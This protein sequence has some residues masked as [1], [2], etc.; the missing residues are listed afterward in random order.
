MPKAS[1]P[2]ADYDP[3]KDS[4]LAHRC[5]RKF[6]LT[7]L[8]ADYDDA[9]QVALIGLMKARETWKPD[10]RPWPIWATIIVF[11]HLQRWN[12]VRLRNGL[13]D[14]RD[15]PD[16][17]DPQTPPIHLTLNPSNVAGDD[18]D[19]ALSLDRDERSERIRALVAGLPER[20][21]FI[22]EGI[23]AGKTMTEIAREMGRSRQLVLFLLRKYQA[24]LQLLFA[25]AA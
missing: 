24:R 7:P 22:C 13:V 2:A 12:R 14:V 3:T 1:E 8:D 20:I 17:D 16:L 15:S 25:D 23:L 10:V 21:R 19:P 9:A 11:R 4:G 18:P 6:G 5:V